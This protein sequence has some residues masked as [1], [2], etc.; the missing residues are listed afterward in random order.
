MSRS[1]GRTEP[2]VIAN[3]ADGLSYSKTRLEETYRSGGLLDKAPSKM[4]KNPALAAL[5]KEDI[6]LL[7]HEFE[8][9]RGEAE[10]ILVENDG[11]LTK[12]LET[13]IS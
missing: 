7:I 12:T 1:N 10:K 9:T 2:N 6:D 5:K 4:P 13:F 11:D 3:F 8:I